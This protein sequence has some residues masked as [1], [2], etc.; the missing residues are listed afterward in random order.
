[1]THRTKMASVGISTGPG[2]TTH[3][4]PCP[5]GR[6][7]NMTSDSNQNRERARLI[8][9][10][11]AFAAVFVASA[12]AIA[13]TPADPARLLE[14]LR[15]QAHRALQTTNLARTSA[16]D[17][18]LLDQRW[19][20]EWEES[21]WR[22]AAQTVFAYDQTRRTEQREVVWNGTNMINQSRTRYELAAENVVVE[23]HEGYDPVSNSFIEVDRYTYGY[24]YDLFTGE[25]LFLQTVTYETKIGDEWRP[26]ERTTYEQ[27]S[28]TELAGVVDEWA[29]GEWVPKERFTLN[30][31]A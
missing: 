13:Q 11:V 7:A 16:T 21:D 4:Q 19:M 8:L 17:T 12:P 14:H 10:V 6:V 29:G 31:S 5:V 18:L 26:I 30:E 2:F 3:N 15:P 20:Y 24:T 25:P 23:I 9:G 1:A 28:E 22:H 27:V